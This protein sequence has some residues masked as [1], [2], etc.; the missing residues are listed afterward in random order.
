LSSALRDDGREK[1]KTQPFRFRFRGKRWRLV[2]TGSSADAQG[3][4]DCQGPHIR[5]RTMMIP[6]SGGTKYD[7][8]VILHEARHA[9]DWDACEEAVQE[10]SEATAALLWE[11]GWRKV[12]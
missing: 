12:I 2:D 8:E 3:G 5:N 4:G 7:L 9:C 10:S 6:I 11:L 1:M